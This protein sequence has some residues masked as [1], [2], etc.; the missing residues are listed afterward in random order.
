M[1]VDNS[2]T[3]WKRELVRL[4]ITIRGDGGRRAWWKRWREWWDCESTRERVAEGEGAWWYWVDGQSWTIEIVYAIKSYRDIVWVF[5]CFTCRWYWWWVSG[6]LIATVLY[7]VSEDSSIPN[8]SY[9]VSSNSIAMLFHADNDTDSLVSEIDRGRICRRSI[10]FSV[11][12]TVII[13]DTS[14]K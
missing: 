14:Q 2:G 3:A 6:N 12:H 5:S 11:V 1:D 4:L 13:Q 10:P 8:L 7:S 9:T